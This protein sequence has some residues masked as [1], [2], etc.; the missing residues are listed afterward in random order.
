MKRKVKRKN[1]NIYF[2]QEGIDGYRIAKFSNSM[3]AE[4]FAK[5]LC[6]DMDG[7]LWKCVSFKDLSD[8]FGCIKLL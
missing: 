2:Y 8:T 7:V 1:K 5:H 6:K 3:Q 4:K